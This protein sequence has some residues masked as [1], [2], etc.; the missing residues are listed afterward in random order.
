LLGS[1]HGSRLV[2]NSGEVPPHPNLLFAIRRLMLE[3][4]PRDVE[5]KMPKVMELATRLRKELPLFRMKKREAFKFVT[6]VDAGSQILML[7]SKH[8]AIISALTYS[9]PS[10]SCFFHNPESLSYPLSFPGARFR[11]I[12]SVRREARLYETACSFLEGNPG[13]DLLLIDGPLAFSNLWGITG[14]EQDRQRLINGV[15]RFL[16]LCMDKDV[17]V[18]GIVKRPSAR[19]LVYYMG[20][21]EETELSDSFLLLQALRS[22]ERTDIFSPRT[23]LRCVSRASTFMDAI[24][25]PIYSFYGRFSNDWS[26][27]PVR[28]DLPVFSL[29]SLDDIA[30]YCYGTSFWMGIPHALVRADEEVRISKKFMSEVYMEIVSRIGRKTG[31]VSLLAPYWGEG[32]WMGA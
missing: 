13:V 1:R 18:A 4:V 15:N 8:Y 16:E 12:V 3:E 32:V 2:E 20:L 17:V 6:G 25:C 27:P 26:I 24:H 31:K 14:R 29:G 5:R 22:G 23:A 28:I 19:Y 21:N 30:D 11:G 9:L 10:G 7:A